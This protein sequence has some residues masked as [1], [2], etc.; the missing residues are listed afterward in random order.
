VKQNTCQRIEIC[1]LPSQGREGSI[2]GDNETP[3]YQTPY[4]KNAT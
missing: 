3:R 2:A 1:I 4:L